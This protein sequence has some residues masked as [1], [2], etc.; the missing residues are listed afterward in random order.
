M[1][2][3]SQHSSVSS[4][5]VA[6]ARRE[7]LRL[8]QGWGQY[9][10]DW[11]R[12]LQLHTAVL[13]SPY[14]HARIVRLDVSEAKKIS[15]VK[16][17][18]TGQDTQLSGLKSILGGSVLRASSDE[19]FRKPAYPVLARGHV[20]HVGQAVAFVVA[21]TAIAAYDACER[22]DV[23]YESLPAVVGF[24]DAVAVGAPQIHPEVPANVAM[25]YERGDKAAV[26]RAFASARYISRVTADSQ[27]LL[28][29]P[30][31]P[32]AA[33][34]EYNSA[35]DVY[36]LY[37]SSQGIGGMRTHLALI[38]GIPDTKL[39]IVAEDVGGS[40]GVRITPYVEQILC[41]LAAKELGKP[42]KWV[43]SRSDSILSDYHGRGL[44][45][46]GELA[47]DEEGNFLAFR[48]EDEIDL[49]AYASPYGAFI[50]TSNVA[51]T[52][53]GAYRVPALCMRSRLVY[54]NTTPVSAYRGAGRPDIAYAVERLVDQA[55]VEH[56]FDRRELR[57]RNFV[58]P[59]EM[60]YETAVGMGTVYDCGEFAD[61]MDDALRLAH[62]EGFAAR[63][64]ESEQRGCWRGL[65][66]ACYLEASGTG[67]SP[68]DQT[69]VRFDKEGRMTIYC[70]AGAS[71][72]GHET[73]FIDIF[74]R[75][76]GVSPRMVSYRASD[77]SMSLVGNGTGGSRTTLGQGSSFTLLAKSL[78]S[79][80]QGYATKVLG[81]TRIEDVEYVGGEFSYQNKRTSLQE[82]AISLN[83]KAGEGHSWDT[84]AE[85][86]FGVTYPNGCH[87]VEVEI[88]PR[89]G[90][91]KILQYI[92]MDDFGNILQPT[93]VIGQVQG[94]IMQGVGQVLCEQ[95]VYD[96][97]GQL[98]SG[99]F[100]DYT[101]P[102]AG[103]IPQSIQC[104]HRSVP[105]KSNPLGAKGVGESGCTGSIPAVVNAMIDAL[106]S[107]G[108]KSAGDM[109]MPMTPS[110]LWMA[111][112]EDK[113]R[114]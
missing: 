105:T 93:L 92:A 108:L 71:G 73:T 4:N 85:G 77:N 84:Q 96:K 86:A 14:A 44:T 61:L 29:N 112:Q 66:F 47:M 104:L 26:E 13:R 107:A 81:A 31:E 97:T 11:N 2:S 68:K 24:E 21:E 27:R 101:I 91:S 49:G 18:Y 75:E 53:G 1:I 60:P 58:T 57:R 40:F 22:I 34:A 59:Q 20:H 72:Q 100:M 32:R 63:R 28:V 51:V 7:D 38:T 90:V 15:G 83:P 109:Q 69:A 16:L 80:A 39:R 82:L 62:W 76:L 88:D 3:N 56:G 106:R 25:V 5:S 114:E 111:F 110:R 23:V 9:T 33:L 54:T 48:W 35:E 99:S 89:T 103:L 65:G 17:I 64:R 37:T 74:S 95:V 36:T 6:P 94:G 55:A 45:L 46:K 70:V 79:K 113:G 102:R 87:V 52:C 10:A 78:L 12:P 43:G 98:L 8:I 41:L 50:G 19:I 30:M 42:V 67:L